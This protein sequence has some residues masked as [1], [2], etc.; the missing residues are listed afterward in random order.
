M[1]LEGADQEA[2]LIKSDSSGGVSIK[3]QRGSSL[4]HVAATH[5]IHQHKDA[6]SSP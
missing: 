3:C 1:V 6:E 2:D 5:A 4:L